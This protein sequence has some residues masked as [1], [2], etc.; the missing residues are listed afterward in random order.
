MALNENEMERG[1]QR[2]LDDDR[3][4]TID[5]IPF[6]FTGKGRDSYL[7]RRRYILL[8]CLSRVFGIGA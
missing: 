5:R 6:P 8:V 2:A 4:L 7:Q 1:T 3:R